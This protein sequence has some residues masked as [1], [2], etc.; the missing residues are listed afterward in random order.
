MADLNALIAQGYQFQAPPDPFVQYAK[1][2]QLDQGEQTN[3]LNQMK[4][5]EYQRGIQEQNALRALDPASATYINDVTKISPEL[6]LK[7]GKLRQEAKTA[8]TEGQIKDTDLLAKKLSLLPDMYARADT[9][10]KYIAL[11]ESIHADPTLGNYLKSIGATKEQGRAKINEAV[12]N[13]TFDNLRLG[14]MQKVEDV[15]AHL[16]D[17]AYGQSKNAPAPGAAPVSAPKYDATPLVPMPNEP[18]VAPAVTGLNADQA[19]AQL[20]VAPNALAPQVAPVNALAAAP[21][22]DRVKQI[23]D[24]LLEGNTSEY[25]NS[26]GWAD[27]K[28]QLKTERADLIKEQPDIALMRALK[29]PNTPAGFTTLQALKNSSPSEFERAIKAANL[30]PAE[31]IAVNRAYL[32]QKTTNAPGTVV[33][34]DQKQEGAFATGLGKGQ[35]DRILANQVVAQDAAAILETNQVGRDLLKSGAITGTGADFFVGFNNALKQAGVDFGYADAA[36]NSQAY[37]AAMGANVGRII[38]QF[39][40]GTGLS[41]ADREYAAQM[42]GGKISLTETALRRILDINDRA[43]NRV[44]DLHNKNVSG[45]K[46]NIPLTVEKPA[47]TPPPPSGASLIPGSTPAAPAS[48]I[49]QQRQ[50]A[51]AAIAK[52]APAAAVRQRFKQNTGQEL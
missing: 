46:T 36:A 47:F 1:R 8:L 45:I 33:N 31:I 41:D 29:L 28:E 51:N 18:M 9:P 21:T 24:R 14:S 38:K 35:S 19:R 43:A 12:T 6:G 40:A 26:K 50:D 5:Q 42:A 17:V 20:A 37:A 16:A 25:K 32:K 4:M 27:E 7:F 13:G 11:H 23:D 15:V 2:Q 49:T 44:I 39:G 3:Q 30:N 22:V 10:D 34:I 48:N 52:G